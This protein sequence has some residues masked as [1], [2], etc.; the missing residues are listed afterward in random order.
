MKFGLM[1]FASSEDALAG[2][3]YSLVIDSARFGDKHGF[4]SIWTPERHFTQ[5][6]SLYPNP[7]VLNAALSQVTERIRLQAGSVVMPLHHPLALAESWAMVDNLSGGRVGISLASGWNPNDFAW[8]PDVYEQRHQI[9]FENIETLQKLWQG[10]VISLIN[11][12]GQPMEVRIYPTPVQSQIPIWITAASNPQTFANA[13]AIGANLLTHLLD[14]GIEP[15][16]NKIA[17]YRQNRAKHGHDPDA[18]IVSLMLHTFVGQEFNQVCDQ[19]REPYC[20]YLKSNIG[21][22]KGLA[23]SRGQDIDFTTLP[24]RDLDAFV[25]FLYERFATSRGLIG[26][27]DSCLELVEQLDTIGVDEIACL[28]DFGPSKQVVLEHL[29]YLNQLRERYSKL[30]TKETPTVSTFSNGGQDN[31]ISAQPFILQTFSA[32][33][34]ALKTTDVAETDLETVRQRCPD[35]HSAVEFYQLLNG[36]GLQLGKGYRGIQQLWL[37]Q[38]EV[39]AEV[40][41]PPDAIISGNSLKIYAPVLDA[42]HQVLGATLLTESNNGSNRSSYNRNNRENN[43]HS[44]DDSGSQDPDS[45]YLPTG[46]KGFEIYGPLGTEGWSHG[47]LRRVTGP[48]QDEIEGDIRIFDAAGKVVIEVLGLQMQRTSPMA[49]AAQARQSG[50]DWLY[51]LQWQ[52]E[53][54]LPANPPVEAEAGSWIIFCDRKGIGSALAKQLQSQGDSCYLVYGQQQSTDSNEPANSGSEDYELNSTDATAMQALLQN[55]LSKEQRPCR[56]II[57]LW[58]IDTAPSLETTLATLQADQALTVTSLLHLVQAMANPSVSQHGSAS[59]AKPSPRLWVVTEDVQNVGATTTPHSIAQ[60]PTW[61][62][63]RVVATEYPHLWGGL[64]DLDSTT[65]RSESAQQ[66]LQQLYRQAS[67]QD[68]EDEIVFRS[69]QRHIVRLV[70]SQRQVN[71]AESTPLNPDAT[72]LITGGFGHFGLAS[73]RWLA[74]KG[75]KSLALVG[76]RAPSEKALETIVTLEAMGVQVQTLQADVADVAAMANAIA[77]VQTTAPPLKGIFHIAG[78]SQQKEIIEITVEDLTAMLQ[79]KVWG[80]WNLHQLTLDQE[81]DFF[82]TTSSMSPI[83]G[84][85]GL[86]HYAAA[87]YFLDAFATYRQQLGHP[88]LTVN[89]GALAGGGMALASPAGEKYT[90]QIG[91]NLTSPKD[92]LDVAG[93]FFLGGE[94]SDTHFPANLIIADMDWSIFKPLY[95][96]TGKRLLSTVGNEDALQV[97]GERDPLW[98][99][100]EQVSTDDRLEQVMIYLQKQVAKTLGYREEQYQF[101]PER[102]FFEMGMDSLM[103]VALKNKLE[104]SLATPLPTVLIFEHSNVLSL[105]EYL[106]T[107]VLQWTST[108]SVSQTTVPVSA[109]ESELEPVLASQLRDLSEQ[110]LEDLINQKLARALEEN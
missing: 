11:G 77:T 88:S 57:H 47:I 15:L 22:L 40:K 89:I 34:D 53:P 12:K 86:G 64:I 4:S 90:T 19:A 27:P 48:N 97:S 76:R 58:S 37:G 52:P 8:C 65:I 36:H 106:T 68:S 25:N 51:E 101:D 71:L 62:L 1:F 84:S 99:Q 46:L 78:A 21:L 66:L 32:A 2:E 42:C 39:L 74:Q 49:D 75:A 93:C 91:L 28:L 59:A 81:L 24:E 85:Q 5:F 35:R 92:L 13:G 38:Q 104:S 100:L 50:S 80:T 29:P 105:A 17:L 31:G 45:L 9:L 95:E 26:T 43:G 79:P 23:Q 108:P 18:G 98:Q 70:R 72:Y 16:A 63:G 7:A 102:G 103:A 3:K 82:F 33:S 56:G 14:Q 6:G 73:A 10:E 44:T 83:F 41:I 20:N 94:H 30:D 109:S 107:E 67:G 54:L 55:L 96:M 60:A 61:G 87:N 110:N 69:G